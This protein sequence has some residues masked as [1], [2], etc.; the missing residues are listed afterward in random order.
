L[1]VQRAGEIHGHVIVSGTGSLPPNAEVC[2]VR[3]NHL[4]IQDFAVGYSLGPDATFSVSSLLPG[5]YL[6]D[7]L[8]TAKG[9]FLSNNDRPKLDDLVKAIEQAPGTKRICLKSGESVDVELTYTRDFQDSCSVFCSRS[10]VALSKEED[11]LQL[12]LHT[13]RIH[14]KKI[15]SLRRKEDR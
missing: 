1:S 2:F 12:T 5:D 8:Y 10:Q 15:E 14:D 9:D 13:K 7:V 3:L 4:S 11:R 6:V